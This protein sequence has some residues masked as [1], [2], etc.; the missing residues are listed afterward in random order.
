M[1]IGFLL[2][3][4]GHKFPE[5]LWNVLLPNMYMT[6]IGTIER[7]DVELLMD[8]AVIQKI[9]DIDGIIWQAKAVNIVQYL[10]PENDDFSGC[11]GDVSQANRSGFG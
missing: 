9:A 2:K 1:R 6:A 3:Q 10:Q 7:L 4:R 8:N 5:G 11:C